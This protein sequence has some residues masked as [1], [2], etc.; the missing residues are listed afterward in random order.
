[1]NN[2]ELDELFI[3]SFNYDILK[4]KLEVV[5]KDMD[6]NDL[7]LTFLG[8]E[9]I[10]YFGKDKD[11]NIENDLPFS[12]CNSVLKVNEKILLSWKD[13]KKMNVDTGTISEEI[14]CKEF[15]F[16]YMLD[17]DI[18]GFDFPLYIDAKKVLLNGKEI[19][20]VDVNQ[21]YN[22]KR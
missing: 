19:D 3:E 18:R 14:N 16:N 20:I 17:T 9:K 4:R 10:L 22:N 13:N 8:V 21:N 5:L 7:K 15:V 1:M 2:A 6:D 12:D 11:L